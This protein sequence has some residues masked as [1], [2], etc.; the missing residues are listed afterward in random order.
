MNIHYTN[1]TGKAPNPEKIPLIAFEIDSD[2]KVLSCPESHPALKSNFKKKTGIVNVHFP[3]EHCQQCP[4]KE[5][6][7]V[8]F[9]KKSAVLRVKQNAILAAYARERTFCEPLRRDATSKCAAAEG[10]ISAI[11]RSQGAGKLR[12]RTHPK[13]QVV[14]G[15]K[16][17]GRNIRQIVRFFQG[18]NTSDNVFSKGRNMQA[19]LEQF[20][21]HF[22]EKDSS[23]KT[24]KGP[25]GE[26]EKFEKLLYKTKED[27]ER[28]KKDSPGIPKKRTD[29]KA[30]VYKFPSKLMQKTETSE[31]PD[32]KKATD[33]YLSRFYKSW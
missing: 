18:K 31:A 8:K 21:I 2:F 30:R 26:M 11:K 7:P 16:M 6:C 32:Q 3:L 5:N 14:M 12:V 22:Q 1:M 33:C 20:K 25:L 19:L 23:P 13:V 9:Q 28:E 15:L 24:I 10:S 4:Q 17:L 29:P 27:Y